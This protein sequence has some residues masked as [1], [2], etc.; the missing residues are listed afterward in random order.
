MLFSAHGPCPIPSGRGVPG[1]KIQRAARSIAPATPVTPST[2][3][4]YQMDS[5]PWQALLLRVCAASAAVFNA[6]QSNVYCRMAFAAATWTLRVYLWHCVFIV[7]HELGHAAAAVALGYP[8]LMFSVHGACRSVDPAS[9]E[10]TL[11][12]GHLHAMLYDQADVRW[13]HAVCIALAGVAAELLVVYAIAVARCRSFARAARD[14]CRSLFFDARAA[15]FCMVAYGLDTFMV[16]M[17]C[18]WCI[19]RW[20]VQNPRPPQ[21]TWGQWLLECVH[22]LPPPLIGCMVLSI[23]SNLD[24]RGGE[25]DGAHVWLLVGLPAGW[26]T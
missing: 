11:A 6:F 18:N 8:I 13:D 9:C 24:P 10:A 20:R 22:A 16:Y 5:V 2:C 1:R 26:I 15:Q 19:R 21:R 4:V 17:A 3:P 23:V 12:G 14:V 7:V 25:S